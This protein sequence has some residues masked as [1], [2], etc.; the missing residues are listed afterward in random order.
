MA[1]RRVGYGET[2]VGFWS[3]ILSALFHSARPWTYTI[4]VDA[5]STGSRAYIYHNDVDNGKISEYPGSRVKPGLSTFVGHGTNVTQHFWPLFE[6][7]AN[8]IPDDHHSTTHCYIMATAGMRLLDKHDQ[9]GIFDALYFGLAAESAF[10]FQLQRDSFEVIEGSSEAYYAALATNFLGGPLRKGESTK[11]LLGALDL[12]GSST[13]ITVPHQHPSPEQGGSTYLDGELPNQEMFWMRSYLSMGVNTARVQ[14]FDHL[15]ATT[16][17]RKE[18]DEGNNALFLA[19]PCGFRGHR[20]T[21]DYHGE[22]RV[23]VGTGDAAACSEGLVKA[24]RLSHNGRPAL[25]DGM[26]AVDGI[27]FYAMSVFYY[28]LD[29]ARHYSAH[30]SS[31][32]ARGG[33]GGPWHAWP[34][35]SVREIRAGAAEFCALPWQQEGEAVGAAAGGLPPPS[36]HG[37]GGVGG[38]PHRY[39][40]PDELAHRCLEVVYIGA[41][42]G[43]G[44]GFA[45]DG[46][47]VTFALEVAGMDVEW[48]LGFALAAAAREGRQQQQQQQG[49][50]RRPS[51]SAPSGGREG[52]LGV[53]AGGGG[54]ESA[55]D[56]AALVGN[57]SASDAGF[58]PG[59]GPPSRWMDVLLLN[60]LP[61]S[62]VDAFYY[63]RRSRGSILLTVFSLLTST[64]LT[65]PFSS[66]LGVSIS[67]AL[68]ISGMLSLLLLATLR[69]PFSPAWWRTKREKKKK[70]VAV[71]RESPMTI[72]A[73]GSTKK[74]SR[75]KGPHYFSAGEEKSTRRAKSAGGN[76]KINKK[77][78]AV[79]HSSPFS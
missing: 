21:H 10:P 27:G 41:L 75:R 48:T 5:G 28:A 52:G 7:A 14:F 77:V 3:L 59:G 69:C 54:G 53:A 51:L 62:V 49:G 74:S 76:N 67:T 43:D 66:F 73:L 65:V 2:T 11:P 79:P 45:E 42:L 47:R 13:Q 39:T 68:I 34:T 6:S 55:C 15:V 33:D 37:D 22:K 30:S 1:L 18:T 44:Y 24:L 36:P 17:S 8:L 57:F 35:P 19:N 12:G 63:S 50:R 60:L 46:R 64:S 4:V 32:P 25:T 23:L 29:A 26:P 70:N 9:D 56:G 31:S 58:Y 78:A 38:P 40:A 16:D 71:Q 72:T 20:Q 61:P